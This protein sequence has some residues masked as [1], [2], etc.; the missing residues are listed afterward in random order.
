[1]FQMWWWV[2]EGETKR[3][4]NELAIDMMIAMAEIMMMKYLE[5]ETET[6]TSSLPVFSSN[7]HLIFPLSTNTIFHCHSWYSQ[8]LREKIKW[9]DW[10][11]NLSLAPYVCHFFTQPSWSYSLFSNNLYSIPIV[12][13]VQS[14]L[15]LHF[16]KL[17]HQVKYASFFFLSKT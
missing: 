10:Y 16:L 15:C 11:L 2:P 14:F 8:Q 12:S 17:H 3:S 5:G 6:L 1:M 4:W 7:P 9:I 13:F